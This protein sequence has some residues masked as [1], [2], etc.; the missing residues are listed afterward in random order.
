MEA[1]EVA[2]LQRLAVPDPYRMSEASHG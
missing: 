2:I 1:L